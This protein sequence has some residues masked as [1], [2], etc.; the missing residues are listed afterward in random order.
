MVLDARPQDPPPVAAP[1]AA[2]EVAAAQTEFA[3]RVTVVPQ[4]EAALETSPSG[5]WVQPG[6]RL[7]GRLLK[8]LTRKVR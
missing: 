1:V 6:P 2:E 4:V 3:Q 8:G 7:L 5:M